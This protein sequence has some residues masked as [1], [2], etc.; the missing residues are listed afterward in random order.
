[1]NIKNK[2]KIN[3][4]IIRYPII[5]DKTTKDIENNKYYFKVKK[6]SNKQEI[7]I[8]IE[9][10]FNVKVKRINTLNIGPKTKTIGRF[11]GKTTQYKKAIIQLHQEYKIQLFD[12]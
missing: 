9:N 12:D 6:N 5:T 11:K 4:D 8:T 7:K 10:I 3:P 2:Y 1:M